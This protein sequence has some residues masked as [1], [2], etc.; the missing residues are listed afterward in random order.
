MKVYRGVEVQLHSLLTS[1]LGGREWSPSFPSSLTPGEEPRYPFY[2]RLG[3]PRAGLYVLEKIS[4]H[5]HFRN[6]SGVTCTNSL[7]VAEWKP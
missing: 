4:F 2:T 7:S 6:K 3:G 5:L 1:A